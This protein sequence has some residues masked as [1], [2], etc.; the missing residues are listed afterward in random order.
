MSRKFLVPIDLVQNELQNARVQNLASDPGSPVAGQVW[1]NTTANALKYRSN[2]ANID[3][4]SRA[5]H[6]GTQA[7]S[8]ISD[9]AATVQAYRLDQF[10]APTAPVSA[11]GQKI[12]NLGTPT[13]ATD[14]CTKGYAD[15][16]ANGTD[17]KA[18]VRAVAASN[19][20]LSATQT[21]DG[22][23]LIAGDR[24][25]V[26]GQSTASQN[27]IYIVAAG[28]WTRAADADVGTLTANAAFFVEEGTT[29][30]DTQWRLTTNNPITVGTTSLAFAQIGAGTSYTNGTG[31]SIGGSVISLDTAV[32]VR[33]FAG[34]VGD[35][36]A[37]S[38]AVTHGLGTLDVTVAVFEVS[39][40][41]E[42]EC[43]VV[44]NS[45]SQVTLAFS[46]AP[47]NGAI[48]VVVHG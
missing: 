24:C 10:A 15:A 46:T 23:A 6:T 26:V 8:T 32:A 39:G 33:K 4:L 40:G 45:T 16:L 19:I 35:G 27:G 42:V 1:Y 17:W 43:D 41:A 47:A 2:S 18:S 3:P 20:T 12:T 22:V 30:A 37:T 11:N 7:A 44:H 48:R 5:T 14:A 36:S 13:L 9:M 38:I 34:T 29:N 28:A 21:V 31:I 25:A